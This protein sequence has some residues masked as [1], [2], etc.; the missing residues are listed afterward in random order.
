MFPKVA[1]SELVVAEAATEE[2]S[3]P[4]PNPGIPITAAT[5]T[6]IKT[7]RCPL[8]DFSAF[9]SKEGDEF[10]CDGWK[11]AAL[12]LAIFD[13]E[14]GGITTAVSMIF[15]SCFEGGMAK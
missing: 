4:S 3:Q 14:D 2:K 1:T 12:E 8:Y 5:A 15:F 11:V 13:K 6:G 10:V 9:F 7:N